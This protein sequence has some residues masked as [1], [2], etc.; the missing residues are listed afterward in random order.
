MGETCVPRRLRDPGRDRGGRLRHRDGSGHRRGTFKPDP[1]AGDHHTACETPPG[2]AIGRGSKH[3]SAS[4]TMSS[5]SAGAV[6]GESSGQLPEPQRREQFGLRM[7]RC[8]GTGSAPSSRRAGSVNGPVRP[9]AQA[10][11][12]LTLR[13]TR[14]R[15]CRNGGLIASVVMGGKLSSG[16]RWSVRPRHGDDVVG[17]RHEGAEDQRDG[18][19]GQDEREDDAAVAGGRSVRRWSPRP[20]LRPWCRC[21]LAAAVAAH[22]RGVDD[23]RPTLRDAYLAQSPTMPWPRT[24]A[25]FM[26]AS[27]PSGRGGPASA[28]ELHRE[29]RRADRRGHRATSQGQP[30]ASHAALTQV[31]HARQCLLRPQDRREQGHCARLPAIARSTQLSMGPTTCCLWE[32]RV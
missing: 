27:V 3:T 12:P 31:P 10:A 30:R 28:G 7:P 24:R 13:H 15:P 4:S 29:E 11:R 21:A 6:V 17:D 18:Q 9:H 14:V 32:C 5:G 19:P 22:A 8:G 16:R 26:R 1:L 23:P 2:A 25:C 20:L